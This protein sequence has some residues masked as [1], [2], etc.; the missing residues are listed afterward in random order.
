M[1]ELDRT[2]DELR[3]IM[4]P[5]AE[6]LVR[7]TDTSGHLYLD[8]THVLK[9]RK[10]LFF[11]AVQV[12]KGGVAYHLMPLYTHPQLLDGVSPALK[13]KM[14]GKSCFTFGAPDA[15]LFK[16]LAALTRAGFREYEKAGY[17]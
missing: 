12:K 1:T 8:T 2:F 7:V 15:A 4:L 10:P 14:N 11:G 3:G 13:K 5:Y 6:S 9:N 16:E 17:V